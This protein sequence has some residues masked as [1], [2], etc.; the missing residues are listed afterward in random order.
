MIL[1]PVENT[2]FTNLCPA[3]QQQKLLSPRSGALEAALSHVSSSLKEC[4]SYRNPV[5]WKPLRCTPYCQTR[6]RP[7]G[8]WQGLARYY[9]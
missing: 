2:P 4:V 5:S 6:L 9:T 8:R 1:V 3:T 7:L